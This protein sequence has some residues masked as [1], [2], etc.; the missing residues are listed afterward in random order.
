M[1]EFAIVAVIFFIPLVFGIIEFG[2]M[3]WAKSTV[4]A[5]ARE[6]VRFAI[7]RGSESPAAADS[8]AVA[9]YVKGRT[10]LDGINVRTAW[11]SSNVPGDTV[12]VTVT[13]AFS[14]LIPIIQSRQLQGVSRQI[15]AF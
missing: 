6:G 11:I 13:Y 15:I 5:A 12:E 8:A 2:R 10:R 14:S 1:V 9:N 3:A 4:T 7:V